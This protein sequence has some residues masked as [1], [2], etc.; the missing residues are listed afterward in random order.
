[1]KTVSWVTNLMG[2]SAR[3]LQY[4]DKEYNIFWIKSLYDVIKSGGVI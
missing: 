3:T 2:M 4:Y 1:M